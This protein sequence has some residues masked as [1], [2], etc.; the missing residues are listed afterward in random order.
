MDN[1]NINDQFIENDRF[2]VYFSNNIDHPIAKVTYEKAQFSLEFDTETENNR[3]EFIAHKIKEVLN[4]GNCA[5]YV[6]IVVSRNRMSNL[7]LRSR[8]SPLTVI[9][10]DDG[11]LD[12]MNFDFDG[13]V[14]LNH[15]I[16]ADLNEYKF[17]PTKKYQCA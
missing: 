16:R 15:A 17:A 4:Q 9:R 8:E 14:G 2:Q 3:R 7:F 6:K 11:Y 5:E 12:V 10:H 13:Y 1:K